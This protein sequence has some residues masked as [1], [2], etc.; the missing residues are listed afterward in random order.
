MPKSIDTFLSRADALSE[1]ILEVINDGETPNGVVAVTLLSIV[2]AQMEH[3]G[4][5]S[6]RPK[7]VTA[8]L[9]LIETV[10]SELINHAQIEKH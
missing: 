10:V 9:F 7:S 4:D 5:P 8:L 2:A 6:R 3:H 1:R